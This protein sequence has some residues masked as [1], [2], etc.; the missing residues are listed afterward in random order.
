MRGELRVRV[1]EA[2][3]LKNSQ[4]RTSKVH[5]FKINSSIIEF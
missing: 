2:K 3:I 4:V 1:I 5:D